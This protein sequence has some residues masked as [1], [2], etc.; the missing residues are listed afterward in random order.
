M[1]IDERHQALHEAARR[2]RRRQEDRDH[3]QGC[4]RH[5]PPVAKRLAEE[6]VM[7]DN[8]DILAGFAADAERAGRRRRLRPRRRKFMVIMN[9]ATS[10][11]TTKSPYIARAS[12]TLPQ[13][14]DDARHLGGKERRQESLHHGVRLS[15]PAIDAEG[16]SSKGF[17]A[18]GRRDRRLGA[19]GGGQSRTSPPYVQRAKDLNPRGDLRVHSGR[20]AAGGFGKALAERGID[21]KKIKVMGHAWRSATSTRSPAWATPRSASSPARHYDYNLKIQDERGICRRLQAEFGGDNPD[22]FSVGGYDGMHPHL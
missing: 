21:T 9:A 13:L 17:K 12:F 1:Q 18:G 8:V 11:I 10:I 2:H 6:L 4:R 5:H 3:P 16:A 7:R 19:H 22:F 14:D 15:R 20:R